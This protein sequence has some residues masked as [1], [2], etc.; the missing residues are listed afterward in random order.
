MSD[1]FPNQL[2]GGQ[3]QRV[4]LARALAPEPQVLLLDEPL[5][6]LDKNLR[7][8][9][10]FELHE[11]Q[12]RFAITTLIVTHDQ[13]E[14]MS[15]SDRI[16]VMNH[17]RIVQTGTPNEIYDGPRTRFVATFIGISNII[18]AQ[19]R[20]DGRAGYAK[21][22]IRL[23]PS[24]QGSGYVLL[25]IRPERIVIGPAA[26]ELDN[27]FEARVVSAAFRGTHTALEFDVPALERRIYVHSGPDAGSRIP[28]AT[29]QVT[30]G[31]RAEDCIIVEDDE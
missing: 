7:E 14:A 15:L 25:S 1:R 11:L 16:A 24:D 22:E 20:G 12:R 31:W 17:G 30:L 6:A 13:D 4:A 2:S 8:S 26:A 28:T 23:P 3:Q 18:E 27:V 29:G 5:G 10:Q 9:M 19:R 21:A